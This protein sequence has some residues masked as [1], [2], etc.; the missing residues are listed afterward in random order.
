MKDGS[1]WIETDHFAEIAGISI[2]AASKVARR[3]HV[4]KQWNGYSILVRQ[5][6][7]RGGRSGIRHQ[8]LIQSLP[9]H[10]QTA[11]NGNSEGFEKPVKQRP[12][13]DTEKD[14]KSYPLAKKRYDI[15]AKAVT[16]PAGTPERAAEVRAAVRPG[17]SSRSI[18]RWIEAFEQ[19]GMV[20]LMR[21]RPANA[22]QARVI[23]SGE[24]DAAYVQAG[25][26]PAALPE[27]A[28]YLDTIIKSLWAV[29]AADSGAAQ[30]A[31]LAG[32]KL[33]ME[34][35]SRGIDLPP[36]AFQLNRRRVERDRKKFEQLNIMRT[37]AKRDFDEQPRISRSY[38][39]VDAM[40]LV[41]IDVHHMDV[42]VTAPDGSTRWPKM[43]GFMDAGTGRIFPH[44]V[45]CPP[46][47]SIRQ[48][49]VIEGFI[50]MVTH[51]E[52]GF[53]QHLYIDNG[54]ENR[55]L[56]RL[57]PAL[58]L[59]KGSITKAMPY[60]A[61]AKPIEPLFKRLNQY[62]FK[63]MPGYSGGNRMLK[64]TQNVGKEPNPY[65]GTWN[66]F[67]A[68]CHKLVAFY[69]QQKMG[70]QWGGR[71][72]H[73]VLQDKVNAG[74]RPIKVRPLELD[75]AFC[76]RRTYKLSRG[77]LRINGTGFTHDALFAL[78]HGARVD[79]ALPW[80]RGAD[81]IAF[82]PDVGAV[83]LLP[84]YA[85]APLDRSGAVASG[86]RKQTARKAKRA[87]ISETVPVDP[88]EIAADIAARAAPIV[89]PGRAHVLDQGSTVQALADGRAKATEQHQV[90]MT[91]AERA[92]A[93]RLKLTEAMESMERKQA[94][95]A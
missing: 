11:L 3:A 91:D 43:V 50:A 77:A 20:G 10:F 58:S 37:D 70:G 51:P 89:I 15:I 92:R 21:D 93:R 47:E 87:L 86:R 36:H 60:N 17:A 52:W 9:I 90:E 5:F 57:L 48:E 49:H 88:C 53:P 78:A 7:G 26:D 94:N 79:V 55:A 40:E 65:P 32:H 44:F 45:L 14:P 16:Y 42:C 34:C 74:W 83:Q 56:D 31:K 4:G 66:E 72:P 6:H 8:F 68:E 76:D 64:K 69:H 41:Y 81:P 71:S 59:L 85:Y 25:Y 80:R 95:A 62:V 13:T 28:R 82:V 1:A 22:G 2:Q 35:E 23:V 84:D 67:V 33:L 27:L 73:Q 54:G 19:R 75:A 46:G 39:N 24:F 61:P 18:T 29:R 12:V 63:M 30:V 38:Q